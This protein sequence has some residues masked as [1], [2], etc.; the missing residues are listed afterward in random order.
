ML[1]MVITGFGDYI[2]HVIPMGF[3]IDG[4]PERE[5]QSWWTMFYWAWWIAWCPFVGMFIARISRGR[6]IRELCFAVLL[7]STLVVLW[8]GAFGSAASGVELFSN[9]GVVAAILMLDGG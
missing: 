6:S 1:G 2:W 4:E 7:L 8:M 5:W 9:G 3:W